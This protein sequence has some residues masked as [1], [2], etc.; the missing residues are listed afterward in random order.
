LKRDPSE[1]L[2]PPRPANVEPVEPK[3]REVD[4]KL[5]AF[6]PP[7]PREVDPP[8]NDREVEPNPCDAEPPPKRDEPAAL[9]PALRLPPNECHAPSARAEF[10]APPR[11][12][13]ELWNPRLPPDRAP[14]L[15]KECQFPSAIAACALLERPAPPTRALDDE[16]PLAP[17]NEPPREPPNEPPREPPKEPPPRYELLP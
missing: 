3:P 2:V 13:P 16:P 7:K 4:P 10:V 11:E 5:R 12:P 15:P 1:V 8:A 14:P 6:E 17:P 9:L